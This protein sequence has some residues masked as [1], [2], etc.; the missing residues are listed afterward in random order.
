MNNEMKYI[1]YDTTVPKQIAYAVNSF[2][3]VTENQRSLV[4]YFADE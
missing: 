1:V 2:P 4:T 3:V